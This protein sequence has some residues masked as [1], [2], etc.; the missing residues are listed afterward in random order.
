[1]TAL[2]DGLA[3]VEVET[4]RIADWI[5]A[6]LPSDPA[7]TAKFAPVIE[8]LKALGAPANPVPTPPDG[9]VLPPAP[10]A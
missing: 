10:T 5:T 8:H 3:A 6:N 1:M 4:T 2:D 7:I 9:L